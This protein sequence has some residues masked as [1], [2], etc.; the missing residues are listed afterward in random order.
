MNAWNSLVKTALLGTGNGFTPPA[1]PD[2]LRSAI[3]LIPQD[4]TDTSLFSFAALIGI[5]NLAGTMPAR[6]EEV[7]STS[8]AE[9]R[10]VISKEAA[11][12]LKR[13]LGGEHQEVLPEFLALIAQ[14]RRLVPP[15]TLPALLGLGKHNLRKRVL[16]VIGERGKW[17]ASQNP[18]WAYA[19]GKVDEQDVWET[20][21]RLERV[22]YLERLRERDPKH[23][24]ELIQST[25]A[26][27][28][29]EERA[30]LI[31]ALS[32]G[33]S[34]D[35]EP[36]LESC[37]DDPRKEVRESALNLLVRLPESRHADRMAKRL[38]SFIQYKSSRL[39]NDNLH[40]ELPEEVD[41]D[42][43]RDGVSSAALHKLLGKNANQLAQMVSLILPS[44][45]SQTWGRAP[46][47]ILQTA[48]KSKW[49]EMLIAGWLLATERA[50]DVD[51]AGAI[52]E[53]MVKQTTGWEG[54]SDLDLRGI[55]KLVPI[56]KLETLAKSSLK[57]EHLHNRHPM[58]AL[59]RTSEVAWS[60]ALARAV[61]SPL[62]EMAGTS[63]GT[64]MQDLP[65]FAL[66][67]PVSLTEMFVN[68]WH[69]DGRK[70]AKEWGPWIDRFCTILRF[71]RDMSEA[72]NHR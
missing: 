17:L 35:D 67:I 20:G 21:A 7:A 61:I 2:F 63:Y 52:A 64:M 39:G 13:I 62:Q 40:I 59:L 57:K 24:V 66:R 1:A 6:Q 69:L 15:E 46:E 16:P 44:F 9:S 58:L 53:A 4:N 29:P 43:K 3:E 18:A 10:Q 19:L 51:W 72:L 25:W 8:P 47:R 11:A 41:A 50:Q 54:F 71:R 65:V 26:Q 38:V 60:E 42:A 70:Y 33:L 30:A 36:F 12:F 48:L 31:T 37:L 34:M 49:K 28:P 23:A 56:K 14:Q 45:W 27:D 68:G 22:E 5:A 55:T 32:N